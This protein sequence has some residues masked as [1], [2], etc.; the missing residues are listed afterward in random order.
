MSSIALVV[1]AICGGCLELTS[2]VAGKGRS[3][4]EVKASPD[5]AL[6]RDDNL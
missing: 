5:D 2:R 6:E 3:E 4:V 1:S